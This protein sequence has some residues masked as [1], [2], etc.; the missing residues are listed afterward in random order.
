VTHARFDVGVRAPQA[1]AHLPLGSASSLSPPCMVYVWS[2]GPGARHA[3]LG[4]PCCLNWLLGMMGSN[5]CLLL[6]IIGAVWKISR[7]QQKSPKNFVDGHILVGYVQA[8]HC[9]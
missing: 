9:L 4:P 1:D 8:N 3:V 2:E 5:L 6:K 7:R